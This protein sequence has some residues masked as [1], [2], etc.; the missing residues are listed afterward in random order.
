[1]RCEHPRTNLA[2][3]RGRHASTHFRS[4]GTQCFAH[5]HSAS[6]QPFKLF[7]TID[8]HET[9]ISL[10]ARRVP[11][12]SDGHFPHQSPVRTTI[13]SSRIAGSRLTPSRCVAVDR[14]RI[15]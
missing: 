7:W 8:G 14:A 6:A 11:G 1:M 9:S 5:N 4:H 13:E 15:P 12:F 2:K 10:V 3:L